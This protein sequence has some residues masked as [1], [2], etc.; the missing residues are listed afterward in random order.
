MVGWHHQLSGHESEQTLGN[1]EKQGSLACCSPW[2]CRVRDDLVTEQQMFTIAS[3]KIAK[4]W[5]LPKY[6]T[7]E[8]WIKNTWYLCMCV[9]MYIYMYMYIYTNIYYLCVHTNR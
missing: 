1:S 2:G 8:E 3:F 7:M 6:S 4:I 5:K 9:Y